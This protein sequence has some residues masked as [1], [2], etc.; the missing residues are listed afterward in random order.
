MLANA[1]CVSTTSRAG[2][3]LSRLWSSSWRSRSSWPSSLP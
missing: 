1:V 2:W 3:S